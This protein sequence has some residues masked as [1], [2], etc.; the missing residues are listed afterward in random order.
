MPRT[1]KNNFFG[2]WHFYL[3]YNA[4]I[5][6]VSLRVGLLAIS[7]WSWQKSQAKKDTAAIPHATCCTIQHLV[8]N[9]TFFR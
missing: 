4:T 2:A 3:K 6:G 1:K 5:L 7:F 8:F 9:S